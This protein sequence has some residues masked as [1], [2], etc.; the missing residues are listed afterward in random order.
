MIN[1]IKSLVSK[2]YKFVAYLAIIA[3]LVLIN[4]FHIFGE[5]TVKNIV[6]IIIGIVLLVLCNKFIINKL[7]DKTAKILTIVGMI[8]FFLLTYFSVYYFRVKYNWDFKWLMDS[9]HDIANTGTTENAF[10]FKIFPNN[11]GA[12]III[13]LS[14]KAFF[15]SEVGAYIINILF[16]FAAAIFSVLS[17]KK[18]GGY[19]LVLNV[20]ILLIG[21]APLYLYAPIVYTDTLSVA[22]PVATLYFWLLAKENKDKSTRK[23]YISIFLMTIMGVCG[24]CVKPVAC[25]VL[26]AI[27]INKI[28]TS[29]SKNTLKDL[30]IILATFI[31]LVS[32]FNIVCEKFII[33]DKRKNDLEFPLTHWIMM[34]LSTPESVGGTSI[35]YGGYN[36]K[37]ADFTSLSGNYEQKKEANINQ[38]KER[39]NNFGINGYIDFLLKKFNYVWNDGSYYALNL[40]GWDSLNIDSVPYKYIV[41]YNSETYFR[42]Y[43]RHFNNVLFFIILIGFI[44]QIF[45]K[46]KNDVMTVL[47]ISIVGIAIF[48]LIWEARSRYVYFLIPVFCVLGACSLC[49]IENIFNKTVGKLKS[50]LDNKNK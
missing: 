38:I 35:G 30:T 33:K 27:I 41:G 45:K 42:P 21:C 6:G 1:K 19:K 39:L 50:K 20:L 29:I 32:G 25:I 8:I 11:W 13:T 14:M 12:L 22:F 10:Y 17:A 31:I 49:S 18:I 26:V 5:K 43:M 47:G 24:Y 37:D 48:L 40:I 46:E 3:V 28:C 2:S 44:T 4:Y 15:C 16:I 34:G 23:Y 7:K 9:A 36:Q